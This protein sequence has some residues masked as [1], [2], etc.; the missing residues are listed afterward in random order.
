MNLN[1]FVNAVFGK[2][3]LQ[4]KKLE[5]FLA[6]ADATFW[7]RADRFAEQFDRYL[8]SVDL[9][10]EY[11]VEAYLKLCKNMMTEQTKFLRSGV[12]SRANQKVAFAEVYSNDAE[13]RSYMVGLALSQFLWET[14]YAMYSFF[15]ETVHR[16]AGRARRY[17]EIGPG[18]GLF[19]AGALNEL[20]ANEY[21]AVDIS[22]VSIDVC[23]GFLPFLVTSQASPQ[24]KLLDV[25]EIDTHESFDFVTMGEVIEHLDDPRPVLEK[26]RRLLSLGGVAF[27]STCANCPAID[28]VYLFRNVCEIRALLQS[29]GLQIHD[30][31]VLPV[32]K[33]T[34]E[35]L[36]L[37]KICVNYAAVV[38]AS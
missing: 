30:E 14:H 6:A 4:R 12:Y 1:T 8:R 17:L 27:L 29:C 34:T 22:P 11:A 19:L 5:P 2:S 7:E 3:P 15:L 25:L 35:E 10:V 26:I 28:H 23:R 37:Y 21:E 33:V 32:E 24:F 31:R 9:D 13:M 16:H 36:E 18:H 38:R 20:G